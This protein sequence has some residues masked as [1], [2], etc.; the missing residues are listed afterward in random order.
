MVFG[1]YLWVRSYYR[2]FIVQGVVIFIL[3]IRQGCFFSL[4][5]K[6]IW[7]GQGLLWV[8]IFYC[9]LLKYFFVWFYF[10][11]EFCINSL[12]YVVGFYCVYFTDGEMEFGGFFKVRQVG[13]VELRYEFRFS[14][15]LFFFYIFG[16]GERRGRCVVTLDQ[17]RVLLMFKV[18][19]GFFWRDQFWRV[20]MFRVQGE[21]E[22]G[23]IIFWFIGRMFYF[24]VKRSCVEIVFILIWNED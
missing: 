1:K 15:E 8:F 16:I 23:V 18:R 5:G 17:K 2:V 14:I 11:R 12:R 10:E 9:Q 3:V 6:Y 13:G 21:L 22:S 20:L 24:F 7:M 19:Y 4:R